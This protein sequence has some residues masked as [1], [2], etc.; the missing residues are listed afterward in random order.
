[1][2]PGGPA[3]WGEA[4]QAAVTTHAAPGYAL[5][6]GVFH[7]EFG[8]LNRGMCIRSIVDLSFLYRTAM[9]GL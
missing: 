6:V 8:L 9:C 2:K 5:P 7:T 3:V 1:M 4:F